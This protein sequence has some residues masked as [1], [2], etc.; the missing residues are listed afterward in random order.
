MSV[1]SRVFEMALATFPHAQRVGL[2]YPFGFDRDVPHRWRVSD[3]V[4]Q[5]LRDTAGF[6]VPKTP[7]PSL[8]LLGMPLAVDEALPPNSLVLEPVS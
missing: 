6:G 2:A 4:W 8:T 1:T 5:E 3:D 7:P